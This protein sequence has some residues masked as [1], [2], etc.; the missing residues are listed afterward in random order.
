M[1]PIDNSLYRKSVK[2]DHDSG[3]ADKVG[4]NCF[5]GNGLEPVPNHRWCYWW[6]GVVSA[7]V[8]FSLD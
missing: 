3:P 8:S 1:T 2:E 7:E 6:V 4:G 5:S